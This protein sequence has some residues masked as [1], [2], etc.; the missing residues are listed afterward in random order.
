MAFKLNTHHISLTLKINFKASEWYTCIYTQPHHKSTSFNL[1]DFMRNNLVACCFLVTVW[2]KVYRSITD[3]LASWCV[4]VCCMLQMKIMIYE[5]KNMN[6]AAKENI[7]MDTPGR[8][9]AVCQEPNG[10]L[11]WGTSTPRNIWMAKQK[12]KLQAKIFLDCQ[13]KFW[14]TPN[15]LLLISCPAHVYWSAR[16]SRIFTTGGSEGPCF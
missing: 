15:F 1:I 5:H 6:G 14:W 3:L 8:K 9:I 2:S 11:K 4:H 16:I 7:N 12:Q 10:R 13:N